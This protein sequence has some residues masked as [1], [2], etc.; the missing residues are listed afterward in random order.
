MDPR[1]AALD[2][3]GRLLIALVMAAA[4]GPYTPIPGV[5][6]EQAVVYATAA[7]CA[8]YC[9]LHSVRLTKTAWLVGLLW[10]LQITIVAIGGVLPPVN[11]SGYLPNSVFATMDN[12]TLPLAV[13]CI[14]VTLASKGCDRIVMLRSACTVLVVA[15]CL[16]ALIAA[17]SAVLP[18][19]EILRYWWDN[20]SEDL[21]NFHEA[22]GG[23]Y[24]GL[25]NMPAQ[26]GLLYSLALI[27]A[28]YLLHD[29]TKRL[30]IAASLIAV[31]G[32]ICVSKVFLFV[33]M[34]V[35]G[36]H[37][38]RWALRRPVRIVVGIGAAGL[39]QLG[40]STFLA[41]AARGNSLSTYFTSDTQT[42]TAGRFG[43]TSSLAP[44]IDAVM[45]DSPWWGYGARSIQVAL[46]NG[47]VESLAVGGLVGVTAYTLTSAMLVGAWWLRRKDV[48]PTWSRLSIGVVL[49]AN[50]AAVGFPA[51]TSNRCATVVWTLLSL[52]ML[53]PAARR[54]EPA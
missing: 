48:G 28:V 34:S 54:T 37:L 14:V 2:K 27:A 53:T 35:G 52:L 30:S 5:R 47:W 40:V 42:V 16:N 4:W 15:A 1:Q 29:S 21:G 9:L 49:V 17:A 24:V 44:V 31:G 39:A 3:R 25:I 13:V 26:A 7:L 22:L 11:T 12:I 45:H 20:Q 41:G 6:T 43:A 10:L 19:N 8:A 50:G 36:W 33:G 38:G 23:R 18:L 46:D 51:M 32:V